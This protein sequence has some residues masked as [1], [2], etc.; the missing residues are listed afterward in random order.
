MTHRR[1][2][3]GAVGRA[4][5][6]AFIS[7]LSIGLLPLGCAPY[8]NQRVVQSPLVE[9]PPS[10]EVVLAGVRIDECVAPGKCEEHE[11][12]VRRGLAKALKESLQWK[13]AEDASSAKPIVRFSDDRTCLE[14]DLPGT[15]TL[16]ARVVHTEEEGGGGLGDLLLGYDSLTATV[17]ITLWNPEGAVVLEHT[18]SMS[19]EQERGESQV[20]VSPRIPAGDGASVTEFRPNVRGTSVGL[21]EEAAYTAFTALSASLKPVSRNYTLVFDTSDPRA[22]QAIALA[23]D[24][25]LTEALSML[26]AITPRS[27]AIEYN[28][29]MVHLGLGNTAESI[30]CFEAAHRGGLETR[31]S[32]AYLEHLEERRGYEERYPHPPCLNPENPGTDPGTSGID[33]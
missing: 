31:L 27:A 4:S 32:A 1:R 23:E 20:L 7:L 14:G 19:Y 25:R 5:I 18:V 10:A 2:D 16:A 30:N 15:W 29:A 22:K 11:R 9:V 13:L 26:K 8:L 33:K 21:V 3:D 28:Q 6:A 12:A 17:R 24:G